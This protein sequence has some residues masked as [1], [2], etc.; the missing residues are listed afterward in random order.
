MGSRNTRPTLRLFL[1]AAATVFLARM[2]PAQNP[3]SLNLDNGHYYEAVPAPGGSITWSSART[4]AASRTMLGASGHLVSITSAAEGA[5]IRAHLPDAINSGY[6]LGGFQ[7]NGSPEPAGGWQWVTGE[8]W[9]YT[10]WSSGEPNNA[11]NNEN[12]TQF[13]AT[14]GWND[15]SDGGG[16]GGYVV[17]YEPSAGAPPSDATGLAAA[18]ISTSRIDL[19]W[20]AAA[21]GSVQGYV[22]ERKFGTVPYTQIADVAGTTFSDTGLR[23]GTPYTY[24]VRAYNAGG[25]APYSA[26]AT[27]VTQAGPA[28]ADGVIRLNMTTNW[29]DYDPVGDRLYASIPSSGGALGNTIVQLDPETGNVL[30]S[31]F[32]GSEPGMTAISDDGQFLY[33][34]LGGSSQ[35]RRVNLSSLTADL[36]FQLGNDGLGAWQAED[37]EVVPHQPHLLMATMYHNGVSPRSV[38]TAVYDDGVRRV[39]MANWTN[40][41]T[42]F[43]DGTRAL[44]F[45]N[46]TT[47]S[48]TAFITIDANGVTPAGGSSSLLNGFGVDGTYYD[49]L[50]YSNGSQ[51]YD[52]FNNV[53]L[54]TYSGGGG[55]PFVDSAVNRVYYLNGSGNTTA[56]V[57]YNQTTFISAG[58]T[59]VS[60]VTGGPNCFKAVG[61]DG[62]AFRTPTQIFIVRTSLRPG[63]PPPPAAPTAPTNLVATA[64]STSQINLTWTGTSSIETGFKIQRKTDSGSYAYIGSVGASV[65][66]FSDTGL[67]PNTS[68]TYQVVATNS[69]SD[70]APSDAA[71][72]TTLR[73]PPTAPSG[74]TAVASSSSRVD[75]HWTD[76]STDEDGFEVERA[77]GNGAFS[78][79]GAVGPNTTTYADTSVG[80]VTTYTYRVRAVAGGIGSSYAV[81]AP[82]TTPDGPPAAPTD[83]T[84]SSPSSTTIQLSWTD[85]SNNETGFHV[86]RS[87]DGVTFSPAGTTD[88]NS[89][90]F[91]DTGLPPNTTYTYRVRAFNANGDSAPS[92]TLAVTTQQPPLVPP[93]N[94]TAVLSGGQVTLS[95]TDNT[96]NEDSFLID[97]A[98][99][100]NPFILFKVVGANVISYVDT[101]LSP[102]TTYTYRVRAN[103][104]STAS[105]PSNTASI[106]TPPTPPAAPT[107]LTA[108]AA[109]QSEIDLSWTDTSA[110]EDGFHIERS[111]DGISF[112]PVGSRA[113]NQN[114]YAD[115]GLTPGTT[116]FYRVRAFNAGGES[117]NSNIA[118]ATTA[119]TAP[120]LPSGVQVTART[121]T[122]LSLA[123]TTAA[124]AASYEVERGDGVTFSRVGTPTATSY[125]DNGLQPNTS[126][127]YRVRAVNAGGVSDYTSD[128]TGTTLPSPPAAPGNL[129]ASALSSTAIRLTWSAPAGPLTSYRLERSADNGVSWTPI[130]PPGVADTL[131]LD[132]GLQ[133]STAYQYRL[134]ASNTGGDSPFAGPV[135]ATTP[136]ALPDP[137]AAPQNL[138]VTGLTANSISLAWNASPGAASYA[139]E[140]QTG[141]GE[142]VAIAT[143]NGAATSYSDAGATA[144]VN[145]TY[146]VKARNAGGES[147]PSSSVTAT[148]PAGGRL[149]LSTRSLP[150]GKVA[151]GKSVQKSLTVSNKG[152]GNLVVAVSPPVAGFS[153]VQGGGMVTL[154]PKQ[155]LKVTVRFAPPLAGSYNAYLSITSTDPTASAIAVQLSGMGK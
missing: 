127:T 43:A 25:G 42:C 13:A 26:E 136:A 12:A 83:L 8:P 27:A 51:L 95:W 20:S 89:T 126:Y 24:R 93:S 69:G 39:N 86:E 11:N 36:Q 67:T 105:D 88:A 153:L 106:T 82:V 108:T 121:Q 139:V 77:I 23:Q 81:S 56:I 154:R 113:A 123:W 85:R 143:P 29:L 152:T 109:G 114:T 141:T 150:F 74:L 61:T 15:A 19:S 110:N 7:P 35:V 125:T 130:G 54:G 131:F 71:T 96:S 50:I 129:Q 134:L 68:F 53:L 9:S 75:L 84:G 2:A 37:L 120:G 90:S 16:A 97:R 92:N 60:G 48:G 62:F 76:G 140:R 28:H 91:L 64:V 73:F 102:G 119:P 18:T 80:P 133:P 111:A 70:S 117:T 49:G 112:T 149:K 147:G 144:G 45:F 116:Y 44:V 151:H 1:I 99:G 78:P 14:G 98:V 17:E 65:S 146:R 103:R 30:G 57:A 148:I 40:R 128:V 107:N 137:P 104:G 33:V 32:V 66:S 52:P 5:W 3:P 34:F 101:N 142:F 135:S 94:F 46:E 6:W 72:A 4:A 58:S 145:Y 59:S 155:S 38:G 122:S 115:T 31:V 63:P 10:N 21:A 55:I 100:N 138:R 132:G 118:Q 79:I 22:I 41:H 124:G 87:T 47:S